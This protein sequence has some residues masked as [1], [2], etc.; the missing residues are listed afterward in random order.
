MEYLL[1]VITLGAYQ[2]YIFRKEHQK[3]LEEHLNILRSRLKSQEEIFSNAIK[4][5]P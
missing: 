5:V 4:K 3:Q 1:K 2:R